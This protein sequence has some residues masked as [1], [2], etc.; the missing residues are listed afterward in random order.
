MDGPYILGLGVVVA[1]AVVQRLLVVAP[2][3]D[4]DQDRLSYPGM[5]IRVQQYGLQ[6][7][8]QRAVGMKTS[9]WL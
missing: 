6:I 5:V 3:T 4:N 9:D 7:S 8:A 2:L 1:V